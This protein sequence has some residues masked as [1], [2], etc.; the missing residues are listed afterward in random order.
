MLLATHLKKSQH[1]Y[2][3]NWEWKNTRSL[4]SLSSESTLKPCYFWTSISI[5]LY[6]PNSHTWNTCICIYTHTHTHTHTHWGIYM[7]VF[8]DKYVCVCVCETK[9]IVTSI[10][11]QGDLISHW[12]EVVINFSISLNQYWKIS[13]GVQLSS[14]FDMCSHN[15]VMTQKIEDFYYC[16]E[17]QINAQSA[18]SRLCLSKFLLK[19]QGYI[20]PFDSYLQIS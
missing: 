13:P 15:H 3:L 7:H 6:P 18:L 1:W 14:H 17:D 20:K 4:I 10:F 16:A 5:P 9:L 8:N 19:N 2:W 11:H 12:E